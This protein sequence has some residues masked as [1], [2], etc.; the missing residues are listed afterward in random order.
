MQEGL[1]ADTYFCL[2]RQL[3]EKLKVIE[4][5][6]L[7]D[8]DGIGLLVEGIPSA[9]DS[10]EN[11]KGIGDESSRKS[12]KNHFSL[13]KCKTLK[14]SDREPEV[15]M[16]G[17]TAVVK[18]ESVETFRDETGCEEV[19]AQISE[20]VGNKNYVNSHR[21]SLLQTKSKECIQIRRRVR[22]LLN[23][24]VESNIESI[25]G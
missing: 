9:L 5:K 17:D 14:K 8:D 15:E 7:G 1:S 20:L 23:K 25:A 21:G 6:L 24:L 11:E 10:F 18:S 4:G 13:R 19:L 3:A 22:G 16:V 12:F 2:E